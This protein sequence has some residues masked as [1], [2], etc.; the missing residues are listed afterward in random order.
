[1]EIVWSYEV[2]ESYF[3]V[4]D[5][6]LVNWT[7]KSIEKFENNFDELLERLSNH[8][9]ICPKS[10]LLNFRKCIIDKNNS[11]IYQ[12]INDKIFLVT[13][14]NNSSSHSY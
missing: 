13:L 1:M 7:S 5:Y 9:E 12:E 11:L 3:K 6:L 10:K 8:K 4:I 14:I 2:L